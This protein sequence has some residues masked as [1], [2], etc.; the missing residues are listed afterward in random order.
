[1][2][3]DVEHR[4]C[5]ELSFRS[6]EKIEDRGLLGLELQRL[7]DLDLLSVEIDTA[8]VLVAFFL[9]EIQ[10]LAAAAADVEEGGIEVAG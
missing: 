8:G 7:C 10:E 9:E 1:M 5:V 4:D 2:L 3:D 6:N